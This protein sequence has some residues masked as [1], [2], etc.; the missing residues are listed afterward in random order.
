MN[1]PYQN[2]EENMKIM[3]NLLIGLRLRLCGCDHSV[4]HTNKHTQYG[5]FPP[6]PLSWLIF[7][8]T[9]CR[10]RVKLFY[11]FFTEIGHRMNIIIITWHG[12]SRNGSNIS[13]V[14]FERYFKWK[15][16]DAEKICRLF[17]Q[18]DC[19]TEKGMIGLCIFF[20]YFSTRP[21][22]WSHKSLRLKVFET[23]VS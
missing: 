22:K 13:F 10:R 2:I 9:W 19:V 3:V 14:I 23:M 16:T 1:F 21:D 8:P 7:I 11:R 4:L 18:L 12:E 15:K 17:S 5:M 20:I 6:Y